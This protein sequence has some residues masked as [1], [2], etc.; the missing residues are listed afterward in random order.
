[1]M[2]ILAYGI[3]PVRADTVYLKNG[4]TIEGIIRSED[5]QNVELQV[6]S[7][8]V[9]FS[10]QEVLRIER[11]G[12]QDEA[13]LRDKWQNA[14]AANEVRLIEQLKT[15]EQRP[16]RVEF[17]LQGNSIVVKATL[18]RK[19]EAKL[20]LDTG[21]SMVVLR[22]G[23][24]KGLGVNLDGIVPNCSLVLA[25][26]KSVKGKT[27][28]LDYVKVQ[29][30]EV[31]DVQAVVLLDEIEDLNFGDGLLGLSFLRNFNFKIDYREGVLV[32]EKL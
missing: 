20:L 29:N 7:G 22:R 30:S 15:E 26:G 1:L 21:A 32:L 13:L 16:K 31:R 17:D 2:V 24:A 19:V 4:N 6:N 10:R 18:N 14:R 27:V 8:T 28:V 12:P 3:L 9:W 5:A 11:S 25:N 23:F